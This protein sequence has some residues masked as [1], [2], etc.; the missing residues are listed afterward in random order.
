MTSALADA[1][2]PLL[3]QS[4]IWAMVAYLVV[5]IILGLMGRFARREL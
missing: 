4:A 1:K 3:G 5:V 2:H